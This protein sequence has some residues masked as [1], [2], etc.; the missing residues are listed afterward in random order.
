M[1]ENCY[2]P[3]SFYWYSFWFSFSE[4][5]LEKK[6]KKFLYFLVFLQ[7]SDS[8][9]KEKQPAWRAHSCNPTSEQAERNPCPWAR[10]RGTGC[11][12]VIALPAVLT[13][14]LFTFGVAKR[15]K[16]QDFLLCS[17]RAGLQMPAGF[18]RSENMWKFRGEPLGLGLLRK[19]VGNSSRGLA[20]PAL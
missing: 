17:H 20:P 4:Y 19:L 7:A 1:Q 2:L 15:N 9:E 16:L 14:L 10:S 13:S 12:D 5:L 8:R 6:K 3:I 11:T 18:Q